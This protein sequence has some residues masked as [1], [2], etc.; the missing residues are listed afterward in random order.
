MA[1]TNN[2]V[3][4]VADAEQQPSASKEQDQYTN[5]YDVQATSVQDFSDSKTNS[6]ATDESNNVVSSQQIPKTID[7]THL[8]DEDDVQDDDDDEEDEEEEE[9]EDDDE[10]D[11]RDHANSNINPLNHTQDMEMETIRNSYRNSESDLNDSEASEESTLSS[12][13]PAKRVT[14]FQDVPLPDDFL[15]SATLAIRTSVS[16]H[17][18][19]Y[20]S[21]VDNPLCRY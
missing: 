14:M 5:H 6:T 19:Q 17:C 10:D 21:H 16:L 12:P 11:E 4:Q 9:D 20:T 1:D 8:D 7:F 15:L 18:L 3:M 13:S 2:E